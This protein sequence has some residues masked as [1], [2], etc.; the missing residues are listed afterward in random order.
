MNPCIK[1][2][3]AV[4][5]IIPLGLAVI[6]FP[7]NYLQYRPVNPCAVSF[8]S[9]VVAGNVIYVRHKQKL[10]RICINILRRYIGFHIIRDGFKQYGFYH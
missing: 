1:R 5:L 3:R 7:L 6:S 8:L 10:Y 9:S 2:L 4:S